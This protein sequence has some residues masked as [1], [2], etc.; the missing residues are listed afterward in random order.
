M[1]GRSSFG[2]CRG[3]SWGCGRKTAGG[4]GKELWLSVE[5]KPAGGRDGFDDEAHEEGARQ[6]RKVFW[7]RQAVSC[8]SSV[9]QRLRTE[10]DLGRGKSFDDHHGSPT[11]GTAPKR[12]RFLSGGCFWFGL[13]WNCVECFEAKR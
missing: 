4:G 1:R 8:N 9:Q 6:P 5:W 12:I 10:L 3:V 2:Y 11:L 13:R 7:R